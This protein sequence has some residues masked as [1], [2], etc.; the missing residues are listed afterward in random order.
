M[1]HQINDSEGLFAVKP[2]NFDQQMRIFYNLG[3]KTANL[4]D[5]FNFFYHGTSLPKRNFLITFDDAYRDNLLVAK[6]ILDKY[7]FRA[8]IFV[9]TQYIGKKSVFCSTRED[10]T[11]SLLTKEELIKLENEG[12]DIANHFHSHRPLNNLTQ[13]EIEEEV[14]KSR[15]IL[16]GIIKKKENALFCAVPKNE[17]NKQ[18]RE[19]LTKKG[20]KLLFDG[21]GMVGKG[22][23]PYKIPRVE[24]FD[25]MGFKFLA[26]LSPFYYLFKAVQKG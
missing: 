23:N 26:R 7:G 21:K 9:P 14:D 10:K 18:T 6:P 12:W 11:K 15:E 4:N 8:V 5:L 20:V 1:Y 19:V 17:I 24:I 16:V 2:K 22:V 13:A 3:Y 25:K